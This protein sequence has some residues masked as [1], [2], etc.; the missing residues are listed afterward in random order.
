MPFFIAAI[1]GAVI[2]AVFY[3]LAARKHRRGSVWGASTGLAMMVLILTAVFLPSYSAQD[4][5]A[6]RYVAVG[7]MY[8]ALGLLLGAAVVL[9]FLPPI[10][11]VCGARLSRTEWKEKGCPNGCS[12]FP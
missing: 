3:R 7:I 1:T 9:G 12:Y 5:A 6:F 8:G 10:C 11:P 2:F 4:S